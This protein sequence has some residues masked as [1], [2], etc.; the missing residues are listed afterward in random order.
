MLHQ[1]ITQ[2][3]LVVLGG[4]SP[5]DSGFVAVRPNVRIGDAREDLRKEKVRASCFR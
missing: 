4:D 2:S 3:V 1:R 5:K